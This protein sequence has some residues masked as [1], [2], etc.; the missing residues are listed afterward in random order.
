MTDYDDDWGVLHP[1]IRLLISYLLENLPK[2]PS[3][4]GLFSYDNLII[5]DGLEL[6]ELSKLSSRDI[7]TSLFQSENSKNPIFV[8][9]D[10]SEDSRPK[11]F[12]LKI[13][14]NPKTIRGKPII[15]IDYDQ[16]SDI[17]NIILNADAKFFD[18]SMFLDLMSKE[19]PNFKICNIFGYHIQY[20]SQLGGELKRRINSSKEWVHF[21][22]FGNENI[23]YL[24]AMVKS[25][26]YIFD[27]KCAIQSADIEGNDI[28]ILLKIEDVQ[29]NFWEKEDYRCL[30]QEID[31]D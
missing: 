1:Q 18:I 4:C 15:L 27:S 29:I 3:S 2:T 16:A 13:G 6:N 5:I 9:F 21:I 17:F 22:S 12:G 7:R 8:I 23:H 25:I 26:K 30:Q 31:Q 24:S 19:F 11:T 10:E 28:I 14:F 20:I